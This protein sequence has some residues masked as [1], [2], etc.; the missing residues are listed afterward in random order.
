L[1][2][3]KLDGLVEAPLARFIAADLI[4]VESP[5]ESGRLGGPWHAP[6]GQLSP[7]YLAEVTDGSIQSAKAYAT[8]VDE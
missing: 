4:S 1:R 2:S 6:P 5:G 3:G 8:M 7:S